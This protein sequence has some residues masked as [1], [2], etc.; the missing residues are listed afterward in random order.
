MEIECENYSLYVV[1]FAIVLIAVL[2]Q[3]SKIATL[4]VIWLCSLN[5]QL[6]GQLKGRLNDD[7][8]QNK[9]TMSV[10]D[11]SHLFKRLHGKI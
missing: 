10:S 11:K 7:H 6:K 3:L 1:C 9:S 2:V 4:I 5:G 8:F